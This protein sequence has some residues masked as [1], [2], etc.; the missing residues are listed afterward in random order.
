M[1][2]TNVIEQLRQEEETILEQGQQALRILS[3]LQPQLAKVQLALKA[4]GEKTT[5]K[6]NTGANQKGQRQVGKAAATKSEVV[7]L[8]LEVL[9]EQ[10]LVGHDAL[11]ERV[12]AKVVELGRS[13][14]GFSLRFAEALKD[15]RITESADGY[16]MLEQD[17][18][19]G[20]SHEPATA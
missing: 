5:G 10:G 20:Q 17:E 7:T 11:R 8:V 12:Q 3:E 1:A 4:L 9:S 15:E 6:L 16:R 14:Q 18:N 2:L 19:V 13:R